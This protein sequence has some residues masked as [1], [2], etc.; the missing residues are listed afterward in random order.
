MVT[1]AGEMSVTVYQSIQHH[2]HDMMHLNH[3]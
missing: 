2:M 3:N 1:D